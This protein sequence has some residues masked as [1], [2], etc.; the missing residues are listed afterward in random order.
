MA[1]R[2]G[3]MAWQCKIVSGAEQHLCCGLAG[4]GCLWNSCMEFWLYCAGKGL[5]QKASDFHGLMAYS[6]SADSKST[7][8]S[9]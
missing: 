4:L 3:G 5:E 2:L 6:V 1:V 9:L 7:M 8:P